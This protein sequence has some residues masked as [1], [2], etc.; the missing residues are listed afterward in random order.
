MRRLIKLAVC[1]FALSFAASSYAYTIDDQTNNVWPGSGDP[2][3][4]D[5]VGDW[6]FEIYGIDIT[7]SSGVLNFDLYTNYPQGGFTVG[8]WDTFSGDLALSTNNNGI[9]DYGVALTNHDGLTAG[10]LYKNV[11]WNKSNDYA[12]GG[13]YIYHQ[14]KIVT[15]DTGT[16]V[17]NGSVQWL[18]NNDGGPDYQIHIVVPTL[19]GYVPDFDHTYYAVATCANDFVGAPEP[20]S[21]ILFITGGSVLLVR[22]M[23]KGKK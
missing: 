13:G 7:P 19:N 1:L 11:S 16:W 10:A 8:A 14:N 17:E 4:Y 15:I 21:T 18:T 23:R 5:R 3:A 22:R 2:E 20:V 12:P 9:F 6:K